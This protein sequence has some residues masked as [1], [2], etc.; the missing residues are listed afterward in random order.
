MCDYSLHNVASR[1]AQ[2]E[3]RLVTTKFRK[4]I[5]RGFAAVGDPNVAV[6]LLPGTEI[7][8]DEN[9][10]CEPSFGIGILPNKKIGYRLARFRQMNMD[11]PVIHHDALEFPDGQVV[12]LTRL[13]VGQRATVLQL[14]AA[15]RP[16]VRE[17][18]ATREACEPSLS[19]WCCA[20]GAIL[21][22][23]ALRYRRTPGDVGWPALTPPTGG[24]L[25]GLATKA[26]TSNIPIVFNAGE[27]PVTLSL[28]SSINRPGGNATGVYVFLVEMDAKRMELL[29][30]LVPNPALIAVL[31]N[32]NQTRFKTVSEEI[33]EAARAAGQ[34]I[35][36][37]REQRARNP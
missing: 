28:V 6:C 25:S 20:E 33:A 34:R 15:A 22:G 13:C 16:E 9:V 14:P 24:H 37:S 27:D 8:F 36:P 17:N 31:L 7:A 11:N 30:E 29:R 23:I 1:P 4:S 18:E 19:S 32:P 3:D 2:I 5:T 21:G 35:E 26:T 12:L 10:E